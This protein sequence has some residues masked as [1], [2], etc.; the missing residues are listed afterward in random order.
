MTRFLARWRARPLRHSRAVWALLIVLDLL[1]WPRGEDLAAGLFMIAGLARPGRRRAALAWAEVTGASQR[2]RGAAKTCE[3]LGRWLAQTRTLGFRS[4]EQFRQHLAIQ[5][6]EH[7]DMPGAAILLGFH[8]GPIGGDLP[9]RVLGYP[10]T[11]VGSTDRAATV[12]WWS[13]AWRPFLAPRP[14]SLPVASRDRWPA[15]LYR[16]HRMLLDGEKVYL[17]A[18]GDGTEVFRLPLSVGDWPIR[19]GWVTLHRLT[20]ARVLPVFHHLDGPRH[21]LT[22]H[23]PLPPLDPDSPKDLEGWR[24]RLTCLVEDYVNRFPEQCP[25]LALMHPLR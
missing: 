13:D 5:G 18:E 15:V 12:G 21:V 1:P 11:F 6:A 14:L 20:G 25:H 9:F 7:L 4:P 17:L 24:D 10:V 2:W 3:F 8:L 22:I 16:V 23:P 19:A